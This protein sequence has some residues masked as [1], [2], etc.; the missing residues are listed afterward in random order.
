M[1]TSL[2]SLGSQVSH[3]PPRLVKSNH[4]KMAAKRGSLYVMSLAPSSEFFGSATA[5]IE[6]IFKNTLRSLFISKSITFVIMYGI[7]G[8]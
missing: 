5:Y 8:I 4:K 2:N 7:G 6:I 3:A 1:F